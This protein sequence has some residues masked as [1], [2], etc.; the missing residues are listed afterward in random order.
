LFAPGSDAE[1]GVQVMKIYAL[2]MLIG[3]ILSFS[4]IPVR[5][6]EPAVPPPKP[7]PAKA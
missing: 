5:Q 7:A 4:Y 2:L 3:V 1:A 6:P